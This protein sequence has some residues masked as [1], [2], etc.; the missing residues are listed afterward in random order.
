MV[1]CEGAS[2]RFLKQACFS[3]N[4]DEMCTSSAIY[5]YIPASILPCLSPQ[6]CKQVYVHGL[7]A[8]LFIIASVASKTAPS[9]TRNGCGFY[10]EL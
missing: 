7:V 1:T 2:V 9:I 4:I 6:M 3:P 10:V 8:H 5:V